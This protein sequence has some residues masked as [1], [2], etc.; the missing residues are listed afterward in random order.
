LGTR[1][2]LSATQQ[3]F[4]EGFFEAEASVLYL[5]GGTTTS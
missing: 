3:R 4:L 5:S 2:I 1:T